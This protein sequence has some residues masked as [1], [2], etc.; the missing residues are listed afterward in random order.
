M[1][2]S[3]RMTS[4]PFRGALIGCGFFAQNHLHAWRNIDGADIVA[5]CDADPRRLQATGAAFGITRLYGDA[6]TMLKEEAL[7]FVDIATTVNSHRA[8]VQLAAGA[9]VHAICQKPFAP[10]ATDA[11]AMTARCAEAR[12]ALMVHEN[13]RWQAPILALRAALDRGEIGQPFW[14]RVS[15]RSGHDVFTAQPYLATDE[16]FILQDL[17]IH[18]L[19]V[20]RFLFGDVARLSAATRRVNP[21]IKGEDVATMLCTHVD[22]LASV[23]D[24]SYATQLERDPFPQTL[25]E[26]DGTEGSLR[27]LQDYRIEVHRK[28][29]RRIIECAPPLPAWGE[30]PWHNIQDSVINIQRHWIDCLRT[31]REPATSGRDNLRTMAL[32][33]AAYRSAAEGQ[34]AIDIAAQP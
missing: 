17:G 28:G 20:A 13:F 9:G 18:I 7:D 32:V 30:R 26:I 8:L 5:L 24:C 23:V 4:R 1:N 6:A 12:V 31:G 16:R 25:A 27:L 29:E 10:N 19:D 33:D 14:G 11:A 15:F 2:M 22:G 34:A 3:V 21:A